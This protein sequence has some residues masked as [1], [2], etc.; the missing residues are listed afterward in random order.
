M[1]RLVPLRQ[2]VSDDIVSDFTQSQSHLPCEEHDTYPCHGAGAA[3]DPREQRKPW[4]CAEAELG[5]AY[6]YLMSDCARY[7]TGIDIAVAGVVGAWWTRG[8]NEI[9]LDLHSMRCF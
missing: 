4:L 6:V 8:I 2:V 9:L 7:T 3:R 5:G 1:S